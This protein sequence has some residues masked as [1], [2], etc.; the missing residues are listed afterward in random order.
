[1]PEGA[2]ITAIHTVPTWGDLGTGGVVHISLTFSEAVR[3]TGT[4]TLASSDG[5]TATYISGSGT[6][7]LTFNHTVAAGQNTNHLSVTGVKLPPG[8]AVVDESGCDN[9]YW[10]TCAD[11]YWPTPRCLTC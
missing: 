7:T 9:E 10:P 5:G 6:S 4:P 2:A 1:M 11:K 8:A 3:V